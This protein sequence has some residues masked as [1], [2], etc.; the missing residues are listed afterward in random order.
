MGD[1]QSGLDEVHPRKNSPQG[2]SLNQLKPDDK[3]IL[4]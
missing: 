1:R 2:V 4:R 3:P